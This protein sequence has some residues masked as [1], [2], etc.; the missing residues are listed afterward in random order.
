M[1]SYTICNLPL[2]TLET[3][4]PANCVPNFEP[5]PATATFTHPIVSVPYQDHGHYIVADSEPVK[6]AAQC[7][8][9]DVNQQVLGKACEQSLLQLLP[10]VDSLET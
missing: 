4:R 1:F 7:R 8:F 3:G 2:V 9:D 6:E 10:Y 5:E